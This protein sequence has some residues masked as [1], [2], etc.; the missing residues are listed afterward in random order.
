MAEE[1]SDRHAQDP[2]PPLSR[3]GCRRLDS[4]AGGRIT[5]CLHLKRSRHRPS[6]NRPTPSEETMDALVKFL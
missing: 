3:T 4:T 2:V 1:R 5:D 6:N